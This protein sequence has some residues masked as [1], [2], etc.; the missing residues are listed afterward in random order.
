MHVESLGQGKPRHGFSK[1]VQRF[2]A[3]FSPPGMPH[4]MG[5]LQAKSQHEVL[6]PDL[7]KPSN[8]VG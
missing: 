2:G 1:L 3:Q 5:N 7:L 4:R 6:G 8:L